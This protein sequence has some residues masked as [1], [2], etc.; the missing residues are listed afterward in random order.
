VSFDPGPIRVWLEPGY[1]HGRVGAWM[2]EWPGCFAWGTTREHVLSRVVPAV[3]GHVDWLEDHGE[4]AR[5]PETDALEIVEEVA[6]T[7]DGTYERNATFAADAEAVTAQR[8][9]STIRILDAARSDLTV[10]I[11]QLSQAPGSGTRLSVEPEEATSMPPAGPRW[12]RSGEGLLRHLAGAEMWLASRLARTARYEGPG[13]DDIAAYL[14]ATHAWAVERLRAIHAADPAAAATDGKG[15]QWTLA[16]VT[17]RVV[18]HALDHLDELRRRL[19]VAD[20]YAARLDL[21]REAPPLDALAALLLRTGFRER[22]DDPERFAR[23]VANSTE[24][25]TLWD[26]E[27]LVAYARVLTDGA[28]NA[29]V[30]TLAVHPRGQGRGVGRRLMESIVAGRDDITFTLGARPGVQGFYEAL[31]FRPAPG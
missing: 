29:G 30:N 10:E 16:K 12:Q 18:Y 4:S 8:L 31:G 24:T 28:F 11:T 5:R 21:R 7:W 19:D 15:E 3:H 14:D 6:P 27:A 22:T 2:L 25:W 26:G 9:E 1:D 13:E 17:R 23:M 20:E